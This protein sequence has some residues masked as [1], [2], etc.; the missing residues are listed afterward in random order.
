MD[1][2]VRTMRPDEFDVV[3][4]LSAAAFDEPGIDTLFDTLHTSWGWADDLSFVTEHN[5]ELVGQVLFSHAFLDTSSGVLDVLVLNPIGV[6]PDLQ[7]TGI[8]GQMIR[9]ALAALAARNE[10]LVFL[11]GHPSYYPRFGFRQAGP[12][13]F[14]APS[15][16]IPAAAF[17]VYTLPAHRPGVTGQLVYPDAFWRAGAVGPPG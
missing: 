15:A 12:L 14:V 8:G 2:I 5:G 10:P 3:R 11:E 4:D 13:G 17:M 7:R 6:R 9:T 16:R 1:T